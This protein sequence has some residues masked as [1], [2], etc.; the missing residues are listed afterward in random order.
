MATDKIMQAWAPY[1]EDL[2]R[3]VHTNEYMLRFDEKL[4][5][6]CDAIKAWREAEQLA[7]LMRPYKTEE[8]SEHGP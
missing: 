3:E 4:D 6:H 8:A 1:C 2:A 5:A 7:Q